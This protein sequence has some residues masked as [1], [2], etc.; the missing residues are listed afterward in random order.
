MLASTIALEFD[1]VKTQIRQRAHTT[2]GKALV[3]QIE[4]SNNQ[5]EINRRLD[6]TNHAFTILTAYQEP[7]FGGIR[8]LSETLQRAK[9]LSTLRP[10]DFLDVIGLI[11]ASSNNIR[12]YRQ[13][14][15]HEIADTALDPYYFDL[16]AIPRLKEAIQQVITVDGYIHDNASHDLLKIRNQI[17][18]NEQKVNERLTNI[19][20][21]QKNRLADSLITLRNNR[22]VVPVKLS[23]KNNFPGTIIDYSSSGE[24]VY[25]EPS[26]VQEINNKIALLLIEEEREIDRILRELTLLVAEH[27]DPLK[28]N[29]VLLSQLDMIF[30]CAKHA[31]LYECFRP[32]ITEDTVLLR[33]ARHPLIA[34]KEVVANTISFDSNQ[35][36]IIITG[37]NTGGKTVALKTMGLLSIMVQSG[38]MI[39]VAEDSKTI[40]FE[41]IFADIGDEQSIEQS[42]S[43][44]SSHMT[45][46]IGII[47]NMTVGSLILLDE[48]GS[49]TDPKEGASLAISLLDYFRIRGVYVMATTHYPELKAYAYDK[50]EILNASVEFDIETLQPTYR[51]LLGTPGKSNALLISQRLGLKDS[52]VEAAKQHVVTSQ[53]NV[54]DLINKLEK[55]GQ[56]LDR[57]MTEYDRLI[58]ETKEL[59][60]ENKRFQKELLEA[61]QKYNRKVSIEQSQILKDTKELAL[62]LIKEIE[63]LKEKSTVKDHEIASLKY[64]TK[65]LNLSEESISSTTDHVYQPG[66]VVNILKFNRNGELIKLQT[67]GRWLVKMGVL[68]SQYEESEFEFVESKQPSTTTTSSI[69]GIK[70]QAKAELDLRGMRYEEAKVELDRYIDDCLVANQPFASII[71]GFGTLTLRN[72]VKQYLDDHPQVASHRDGEGN[73]GGQGVT[74]V[75]FK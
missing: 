28:Q 26:S 13:V 62:N 22:Y 20:H 49:G 66:D 21:S 34:Q 4:P 43:T 46:I 5:L 56:Q 27:H 9:I 12:F 45:R 75:K 58:Q 39:P 48:L 67:N 6:E 60:N 53:D 69:K 51:L 11:E 40:V 72:L 63:A 24:T 41:H 73:E 33:H 68:S 55:Q 70:K 52:I 7:P 54:A 42:L 1:K 8:D 31:V 19:L 38:L 29:F 14:K 16:Q 74:V 10:T 61:K 2:M 35:R 17:Q 47:A 18:R 36:I 59:V 50:E 64:K 37:P 44:F 25:M 3:D 65:Q 30:A 32:E 71:H 23:E 57:K 15:E